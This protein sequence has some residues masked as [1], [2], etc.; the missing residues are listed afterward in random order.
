MPLKSNRVTRTCRACG[1]PFQVFP[2][3]RGIY[4]SPKCFFA[5]KTSRAA[6]LDK[7]W[8]SVE[9]TPTCWLWL[10]GKLFTYGKFLN[11][12]AHRAAYELFVGPVP[13]DLYVC[14][15]CDTPRCVNPTHL[16]LGTPQDNQLDRRSKGRH[17][18]DHHPFGDGHPLAKLTEADVR[19]IR[20]RVGAGE[21]FSE[22][23]REYGVSNVTLRAAARG[24]TWK[25]LA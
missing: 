20:Q 21:N 16:F 15:R 9:I 10:P 13:D 19:E 12:T 11:T 4:C 5:F 2:A 25:H 7:F 8:Q 17:G 3:S 14:H 18:E 1:T 23:A 24:D 22:L 6:R